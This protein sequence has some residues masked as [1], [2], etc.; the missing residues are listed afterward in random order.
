ML[1]IIFFL[2]VE[3]SFYSRLR[4]LVVFI[5]AISYLRETNLEKKIKLSFKIFDTNNNG[6]LE[7][8]EVPLL[9]YTF[10][11]MI[12]ILP[13]Y[14]DV[15]QLKLKALKRGVVEYHTRF[16]QDRTKNG[17]SPHKKKL[18]SPQKDEKP[19]IEKIIFNQ[20]AP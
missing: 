15:K 18:N 8:D 1:K 3:F 9:I 20:M 11:E 7:L 10:N 19:I 13:G 12:G 6:K 5:L 16:G 17:K 14:T 4:N 2:N